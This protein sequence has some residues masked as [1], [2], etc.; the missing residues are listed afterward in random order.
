VL[1]I[2]TSPDSP[3]VITEGVKFYAFIEQAP[4]Q[5]YKENFLVTNKPGREDSPVCLSQGSLDYLVYFA[6]AEFFVN[7][8]RLTPGW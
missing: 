4:E 5:F 1:N 2:S 3:F 7:Q 6:P 8:F